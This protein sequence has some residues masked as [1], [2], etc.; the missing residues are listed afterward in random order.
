M[1]VL[2]MEVNC[3]PRLFYAYASAYIALGSIR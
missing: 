2:D 3:L 1:V